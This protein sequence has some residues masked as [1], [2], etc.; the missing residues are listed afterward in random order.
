MDD[1]IREPTDR[2]LWIDWEHWIVSFHEVEGYDR[3]EF[4]SSQERMEDVFR[5]ASN[6][7]RIQ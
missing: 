1:G 5:K 2:F 4:S 3:V 7:F 6:G